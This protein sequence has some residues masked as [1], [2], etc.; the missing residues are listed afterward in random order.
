[1]W[2][3]PKGGGDGEAEVEECE[4]LCGEAGFEV[5]A[6]VALYDDS[7]DVRWFY[8]GCRCPACGLVG[9]YG[10]WSCEFPGYAE[11]LA[12]V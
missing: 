2:P 9:C 3:P 6:G 1:M 7:E 11:L 10:D 12:R 8:V 5:T 4:C